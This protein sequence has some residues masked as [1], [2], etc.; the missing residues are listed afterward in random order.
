MKHRQE[1]P[2]QEI[3][4]YMN[5]ERL[6]DNRKSA[7]Q[8]ASMVTVVKWGAALLIAT[9]LT[10]TIWFV[11]KR[12]TTLSS[13]QVVNEKKTSTNNKLPLKDSLA[14]NESADLE[15]LPIPQKERK[16]ERTEKSAPP[17]AENQEATSEAESNYIQAE[18]IDGYDALYEY[19]D[20]NLVYPK[21]A[22]RDSIQG[23]QTVSFVIN[24]S[25]MPEQIQIS[26]PLGEAFEREARRLIEN[27][28]QWKPAT[29]NG[30]PVPSR[31]SVPLTFSIQSV[32]K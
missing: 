29:L 7:L 6:L 5:F 16:S 8:K 4:G 2:D 13:D 22:I 27:M 21:E 32:E 20:K 17:P 15:P 3:Q 12:E 23:I 24:A 19:F 30:K 11:S 9:S 31:I 14:I 1:L 18:P 28:P 25:G 10:F 26:K